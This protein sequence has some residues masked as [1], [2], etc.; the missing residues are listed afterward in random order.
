MA[1]KPKKSAHGSKSDE[2]GQ[3]SEEYDGGFYECEYSDVFAF[4]LT[5][6]NGVT[7]NLAVLPE[8]D[9]PIAITNIHPDNGNCGAANPEYFH[10]YTPQNEPDIGYDGRTVPLIAQANVNIGETYHIKL[11]VA[12]ASD[13]ILDSAV[14]ILS[15][16]HI[17]EPTRR[18]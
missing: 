14:F 9:I 16:I 2:A 10:S 15:L 5:D 13:N 1:S 17:S 3:A 11:A 4:L 7:T 18:S 12:D 6:Q 8:T